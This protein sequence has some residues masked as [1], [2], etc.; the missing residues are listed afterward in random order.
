MMKTSHQLARELLAG[1]D[2]PIF[3]FDPSRAGMDGERDT[4]LA[5]ARTEVC[6]DGEHIAE[7]FIIVHGDDA[8]PH[9]EPGAFAEL[10]IES[11]ISTGLVTT[12]EV[13]LAREHARGVVAAK[14]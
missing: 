6:D 3:H 9:D 13:A 11:L 8:E 12:V 7:P 4:S 10:T 14:G 5:E 1:P 2:L